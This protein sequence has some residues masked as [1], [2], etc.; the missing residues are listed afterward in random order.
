[1]TAMAYKRRD[2]SD[3]GKRILGENLREAREV[4][5]QIRMGKTAAEMIGVSPTQMSLWEQGRTGVEL[6]R[7]LDIAAAY[8][9]PLDDLV[10][11]LNT[12]YDKVIRQRLQPNVRRMMQA[13]IDALM[14]AGVAMAEGAIDVR[15]TTPSPSA[16]TRPA[17]RKNNA[18]KHPTSRA[19]AAS[20]PK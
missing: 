6:P 4:R 2:L 1:M 17:E 3:H 18:G 12:E 16:A 8:G 20:K 7:L 10:F 14:S 5:A 9:V 19:R 15:G 13:Q 11:G